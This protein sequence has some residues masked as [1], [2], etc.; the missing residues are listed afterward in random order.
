[1]NRTRKHYIENME[2]SEMRT[3]ILGGYEQKVLIKG[4]SKDN[5]IVIFLHGGPGSPIPFCAGCRGMFPEITDQVTMVYWDQLGCG[6]N[7]LLIDNSFTIN[8][9]VNMTIELIH[10]IK[11]DFPNNTI[12]LFAVSWGSALSARVVEAV[13]ELIHSVVAYGQVLK[14]LTFNSEVFEA[15]EQ[16][17]MPTSRKNILNKIKER[18]SEYRL[19]DL[20]KIM[21]WVRKYTEGYQSKSGGKT[22]IGEIL[23]GILRSPDYSMKDFKAIVVNGYMKNESLL[24]ELMRMDLSETLHRIKVPYLILQGD[25]DIVTSTR[26]VEDYIKNS[27]NKNLHFIKVINSGHMPSAKGMDCIIKNGFQFLKE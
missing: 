3:Y 18:V 22:P 11:S 2:L 15:L 20:K 7:N 27:D 16:S 23:W 8:H 14:Q 19:D 21:G 12:N 24:K 4:K 6:I 26:M 5:P 1:M 9:F 17:E 13:P 10:H 25:T